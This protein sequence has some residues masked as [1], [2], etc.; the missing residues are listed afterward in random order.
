M[1]ELLIEFIVDGL[2]DAAS[3]WWKIL[4]VI[5]LLMAF[6][7]IGFTLIYLGIVKQGLAERLVLIGAGLMVLGYEIHLINK[8]RKR[9]QA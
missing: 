3:R 8:L 6:A 2:L 7:A 4:L 9:I 5:L 1:L